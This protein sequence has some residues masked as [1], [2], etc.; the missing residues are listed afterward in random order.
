[1]TPGTYPTPS[2]VTIWIG[3]RKID[4]AFRV[5]WEAKSS[6]VP[7]YGWSDHKYRAMA[8]GREMVAGR[9]V[10]NYR[11]PGYLHS[12]LFGDE[13]AVNPNVEKEKQAL[14]N[15][16][17]I[18]AQGTTQERAQHLMRLMNNE[19]TLNFQ[20][21]TALLETMF[22]PMLNHPIVNGSFR[23]PDPPYRIKVKQGPFQIRI[24]YGHPDID[25]F[26]I[27]KILNG[28][29]IIGESQTISGAGSGGSDLSSSGSPIYEVYNFIARSIDEIMRQP[30]LRQLEGGLDLQDTN[31]FSNIV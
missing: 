3:D 19:D 9:L 13:T 8:D 1:M 25:S 31:A 16:M 7:L 2:N 17:D 6:K 22:D 20:R 15:H 26:N 24:L 29:H 27:E 12:A 10:I 28:V 11:Y 14:R 21:S 18:L 30:R 4:D 23:T 5:D